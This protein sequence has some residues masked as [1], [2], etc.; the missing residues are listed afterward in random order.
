MSEKKAEE[1]K[2]QEAP[3]EQMKLDDARRVK[4]LSPGMLVFKRFIRNKLAVAGIII[5]AV[6]FTFSFLGPL[7]SP[8]T[9][10]QVF[11][12][13]V[14]EPGDYATGK[15]NTDSR[16][17]G[18]ASTSMQSAILKALGSQKSGGKYVLTE[19]QD[20]PFTAKNEHYT[21]RV[22]NPSET[23]PAGAVF[24]SD[25]VATVAKGKFSF[26]DDAKVDEGMKAAILADAEAGGKNKELVYND[27]T[28]TVEASKVERKYYA[29]AEEPIALST[30]NIYTPL[31]GKIAELQADTD[32]LHDINVALLA[33]ESSVSYGGK[34]YSFT[35][36]VENGFVLSDGSQ[37]LF[38]INRDFR[39]G[40]IM[41]EIEKE[42]GST[43][44]QEADYLSTITDADAFRAAINE[45][46]AA[47]EPSFEFEEKGFTVDTEASDTEIHIMDDG[48]NLA[49]TLVNSFDPIESKYDKL[50]GDLG[51]TYALETAIAQEA[52][53]F[54]YNG[55]T[56]GLV[57]NGADFTVTNPAGDAILLASDIAYG[58]AFNGIELTVDFVNKLQEAMRGGQ[59]SFS[60]V[61]Q[62]GEETEATINIVNGNYYVQ[63]MQKTSLFDARSAPNSVHWMGTDVNGM[64]VLTRL[65]YGGRVSL[66]VG[67]VVVIFEL[68]LGVL[69]G[70][71]SGYFGGVVDTILMR[72][73]E[74]FNAIPFYPMLIILGS[75]MDNLHV[76]ARTRLMMTMVIL[77][78]LGWTGI[79]R[80]VRGQI[81]SLREQDFMIAA[82]ATG[83]RTSRRIF[84][85]LVPN[86][87]PLL[88]VN[89]TA[90]LGGII[91]TEATLG[92]LGLGVKYPMASW[93]SII[94]QVNDMQV[95]KTAWWIWIPAGLFILITVLGFN[96]VGDGLRDAFDPK[97]KR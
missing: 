58:P 21:L 83:I 38:E 42:D 70:G 24:G 77:G 74:L 45:A 56:F 26:V 92:F 1:L 82:E 8:Y 55:E 76:D 23:K 25:H 13:D 81:L 28:I 20:I 53:S 43:E 19:G 88:I 15:F 85:H 84:R 63:T 17:V 96:F 71:I 52:S 91:L 30:Y 48:G 80:L 27:V 7:F 6:M 40:K 93:G 2:N 33:G 89:A 36:D 69:V 31:H 9:R 44:S 79:A 10:A 72:F 32:F 59:K 86:V 35:G 14:E 37:G 65:M 39:S 11:V 64:D 22:V 34:T 49:M 18:N 5:L 68:V 41:V 54:E 67:F 60:F 97:M 87:M 75:V 90:S 95:M 47:G 16:F 66:I 61:D 51:F 12:K 57:N 73:V 3:Q 50:N 94:N 46:V 78:I 29:P 4:V 62:Y